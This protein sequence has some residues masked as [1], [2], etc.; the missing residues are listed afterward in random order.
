MVQTIK[1]VSDT[2][3]DYEKAGLI[4]NRLRNTEE[5]EKLI[6]PEG[7]KCLGWV[8]ED[9]IIRSQDI[10]GKSI[11]EITDSPAIDAVKTACLLSE[12]GCHLKKKIVR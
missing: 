1:A 10:V 8:P 7:L 12:Y 9:D 4:V 11:L 3:I 6:I 5:Y 2:A